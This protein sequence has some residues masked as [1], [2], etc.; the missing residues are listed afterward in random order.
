MA[1]AFNLIEVIDILDAEVFDEVYYKIRRKF[2]LGECFSWNIQRFLR[3]AYSFDI[4]PC[5]YGTLYALKR[6]T[7]GQ[8]FL[9][10]IYFEKPW[11]EK[12][13]VERRMESIGLSISCQRLHKNVK[14][15]ESISIN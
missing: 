9:L 14:I 1:D 10:S 11:I 13:D 8:A 12:L 6:A 5:D 15:K 3:F 7:G 4:S 2:Y